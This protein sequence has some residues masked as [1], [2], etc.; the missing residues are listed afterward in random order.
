MALARLR[1]PVAFPGYFVV[2]LAIHPIQFLPEV[3][4]RLCFLVLLSMFAAQLLD[5]FINL[6]EPDRKMPPYFL[7][8]ETLR[9]HLVG[10]HC[11]L[12]TGRLQEGTLQKLA[13]LKR[14]LLIF[15]THSIN[16]T[17]TKVLSLSRM[18]QELSFAVFVVFQ[19]FCEFQDLLVL[20]HAF[21]PVL[22]EEL[23]EFSASAVHDFVDAFVHEQFRSAALPAALVLVE[24]DHVMPSHLDLQ[25]LRIRAL[26]R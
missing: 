7:L 5:S 23:C 24:H 15:K 20:S 2:V 19:F 21:L 12:H 14:E 10:R 8:I 3:F 6:V 26:L 25:L 4:K 18:S 13:L 22:V 11:L 16:R 9:K 17:R 1:R